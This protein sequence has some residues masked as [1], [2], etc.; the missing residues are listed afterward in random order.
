MLVGF[1]E[2]ADGLGKPR[3]GIRHGGRQRQG[4]LGAR[5]AAR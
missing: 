5:T 3:R 1:V 2:G 4:R